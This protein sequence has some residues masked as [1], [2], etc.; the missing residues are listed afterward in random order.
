MAMV[1]GNDIGANPWI[2]AETGLVTEKQIKIRSFNYCEPDS[3]AHQVDFSDSDGRTLFSLTDTQRFIE[4]EGWVHGLTV[5]RL[6]SGYVV[7]SL[8]SN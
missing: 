8:M 5:D 1:F 7:I 3:S 2:V 6:D 4:F